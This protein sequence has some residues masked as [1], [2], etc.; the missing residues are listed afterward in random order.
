MKTLPK[1]LLGLFS[2]F[3]ALFIIHYSLFTGSIRAADPVPPGKK[4][5]GATG[6]PEFHSLR[7]YQANPCNDA[8]EDVALF[9]GNDLVVIQP[10]TVNKSRA[11][12]C[13]TEGNKEICEFKGIGGGGPIA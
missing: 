11:T 6:D 4:D 13:R 5:C 12:S 7:P 3:L 1:I 8:V 9:C 10:L 2:F